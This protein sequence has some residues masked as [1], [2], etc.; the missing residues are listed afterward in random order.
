MFSLGLTSVTFRHL[1]F[2]QIPA[3]CVQAGL[4]CIEWGGDVHVPPAAPDRAIQAAR[5]TA[6]AGLRVSSYGSYYRC[7]EARDA[8][9]AFAPHLETARRLGAPVVRLWAGSRGS[10]EA[11]STYFQRI[12]EE[13]RALCRMAAAANI[14]LAFEYH[15]HTLTDCAQAAVRLAEAVGMVNCGLYFQADPALSVQ[16]NRRALRRLLPYLKKVH[17]YHCDPA[18]RRLSLGESGGSAL[19]RELLAELGA[20]QVCVDLLFEFLKDPTPEGLLREAEL[21]RSLR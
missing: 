13:T 21:L 1:D 20:A 11:D 14:T 9:A 8:P 17:V 7:G 16:E 6:A 3:C 4:S 10:R 2:R 15:P 12:A 18:F 19:W 5:L